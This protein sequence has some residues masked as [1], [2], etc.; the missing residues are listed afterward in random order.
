MRDWIFVE[1]HA[2]GLQTVLEE[3]AISESYNIGADGQRTNLN[4]VET[5][6]DIV[7]E[8]ASPL[9]KSRR[10]LI[11]F[12]PDRPGHDFRYAIDAS[13]VKRDLGWA[14]QESFESGLRKTVEWYLSNEAW[15]EDAQAQYAGQRLGVSV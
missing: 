8:L 9:G 1:D 10:E 6:C 13:K 5:I 7:D 4:V 3:G 15:T 2:R 11:T 14:P 12:V